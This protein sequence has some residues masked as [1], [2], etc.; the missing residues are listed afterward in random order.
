MSKIIYVCYRNEFP[1]NEKKNISRI[2]NE[3][4]AD[5]I[6]ANPSSIFK[7]GNICY[8]LS[9][10][11]STIKHNGRNILLGK[12]FNESD[13]WQEVETD[14]PDGNY[15]ICRSNGIKIEL[16][17]DLVGT[18]TVWYYKDEEKFIAA[19]SQRA[20]IKFL[21]DF[22]FDEGVISW[23]ISS[24]SLGPLNSWDKRIKR[25]APGSIT[26]DLKKWEL[27][28]RKNEVHF[29]YKKISDAEH[30][31]NLK[32]ALE[33]S[34][35]N[36][37]VDFRKWT[38]S[39][40]GGHDCRGILALMDKAKPAQDKIETVTWGLRKAE[41]EKK[42]DAYVAREVSNY[43]KTSH[44]YYETDTKE[45]EAIDSVFTRFLLNGEGRIDHISGYMDGFEIWKVLFE[46]DIEGVIR[47]NQVFGQKT[48]HSAFAVRSF[49]GIPLC[50]D[51]DN[52]QKFNYIQNLE[53]KLPEQLDRQEGESLSTWRDRLLQ[54]YRLPVIQAALSDLKFPYV[55]QFDPLLSREIIEEVK[56]LPDHLRDGK[57]LYQEIVKQLNPGLGYAS[58]SATKDKKEIVAQADFVKIIKQ[59]LSTQHALTIF[60]EDFLND[61]NSKLKD[62]NQTQ[63]LSIAS[64]KRLIS[65]I[66]PLK[67][68]KKIYKKV[69]NPSLNNNIL[70]FRLAIICRMTRIFNEDTSESSL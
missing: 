1:V 64:F 9:N 5:N 67:M 38:L 60:P 58:R 14:Y 15:L 23:M 62:E 32:D 4:N 41:Q 25:L 30:Q 49:I 54:E 2:C 12:L 35:E 53:Q 44:K 70:A 3:I 31:A 27:N 21:K 66:L 11:V 61:V 22:Q 33:K 17:T 57:C 26:L 52:L 7:D 13:S 43:F 55:E 42:S 28:K 37:N 6:N 24:G 47:G 10:P 46:N 68:K 39:L 69:I 50:K 18:R 59:E 8:G 65:S 20:I 36:L 19:T 40:S 63:T 45:E 29:S 51:F 48:P 56:T 16:V 34:F